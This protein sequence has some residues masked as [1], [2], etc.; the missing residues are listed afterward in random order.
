MT[1]L[2]VAIVISEDMLTTIYYIAK[3]KQRVLAF[4]QVVLREWR[5]EAFGPAAVEEA[6][7]RCM[8][9]PALDFEDVLQCLCAKNAGCGTLVTNDRNFHGCG[10]EIVDGAA[11]LAM[12]EKHLLSS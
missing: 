3:E 1:M 5:V 10:V 6:V 8:E 11:A 7:K 12:T 9:D 4:F 2:D